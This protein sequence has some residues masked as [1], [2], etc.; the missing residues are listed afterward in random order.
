LGICRYFSRGN[1]LEQL[2]VRCG[3]RLWIIVWVFRI[4]DFDLNE[5]LREAVSKTVEM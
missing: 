2:W 4:I 5:G 3:C 1:R